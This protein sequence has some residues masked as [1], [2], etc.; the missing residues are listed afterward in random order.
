M[1]TAL[2]NRLRIDVNNQSLSSTELANARTNLGLGT[3]ATAAS[4]AFVAVSGDEMT[5]TLKLPWKW[6]STDLTAN[7]FYVQRSA[8]EDGFAFGIGTGSSLT[9]SVV[10]CV[11]SILLS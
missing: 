7:S 9:D 5:G 2:G 8:T 10:S 1:S 6:N 11:S 3:A 4:T